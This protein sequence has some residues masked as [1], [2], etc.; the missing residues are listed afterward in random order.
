MKLNKIIPYLLSGIIVGGFG[1]CCGT[2][3]PRRIGLC[4]DIDMSPADRK[5]IT[6]GPLVV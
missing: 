6:P 2:I 3:R 5:D 1:G 4:C